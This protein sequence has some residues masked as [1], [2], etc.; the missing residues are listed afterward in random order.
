LFNKELKEE[1]LQADLKIKN[2]E[3]QLTNAEQVIKDLICELDNMNR[4]PKMSNPPSITVPKDDNT[5][6]FLGYFTLKNGR[7]PR[8]EVKVL[9]SNCF[10][11]TFPKTIYRGSPQV[12]FI[13]TGSHI[14]YK[15]QSPNDTWGH[16]TTS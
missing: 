7:I 10:Y 11:N 1:L 2:M 8:L 6:L 5:N 13:H 4:A 9:Q 16:F 12:I 14:L 3:E 15:S